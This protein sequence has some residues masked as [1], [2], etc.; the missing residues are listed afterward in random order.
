MQNQHGEILLVN[1]TYVPGWYLPGGGVD[2]GE[3]IYQAIIR[4][5]YEDVE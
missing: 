4:E 2:H 3:N 1:H 5:V